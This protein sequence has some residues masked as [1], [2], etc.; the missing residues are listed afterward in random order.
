M[1]LSRRV[2]TT[3][4]LGAA[5]A[6]LSP[7]WAQ[8]P[9]SG[10]IAAALA[11]L[12]ATHG[13]RLG[14]AALETGSGH[15]IAYRA[16][17]PFPLTSTH[18]C[19]SAAAVLARVDRGQITLDQRVP[20]GP[21]DL[22]DYAPV[23]GQHVGQGYLTVAELCAA[24]VTWSDNP[25]GNLLLGLI[26][27]PAGWTDYVRALGDKVSRL[28]RTEPTLNT[29]L[30]GDPRDT[31]DP[32]SMLTDLEAVLLGQ[33]L[34]AASRAQLRAWMLDSPITGKLMREGV[35]AGWHVADKSGAGDNGTRNDVGLLIPPEAPPILLAIYQTASPQPAA[36]RDSVI[37]E[38]TRLV[39]ANLV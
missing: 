30:A 39:I 16:R 8:T 28:D 15:R 5:C 17:E 3:A 23:T 12:E 24:A 32:L 31:T 29:A 26:G 33:A 25:A 2:F 14:V 21:A 20:Y 6:G 4:T 11:A 10:E 38:V 36:I 7:V 19:L 37:A 18:K 27:G 1:H 13:G 35:P 34:S 9:G 22:I